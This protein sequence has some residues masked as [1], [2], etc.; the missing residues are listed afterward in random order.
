MTLL[1]LGKQVAR[2]VLKPN[3]HAMPLASGTSSSM[4]VSIVNSAELYNRY[5]GMSI[6]VATSPSTPISSV[7]GSKTR[8]RP[9]RSIVSVGPQP[10]SQILIDRQLKRYLVLRKLDR[11]K[12]RRRPAPIRPMPS[13][14]KS[15]ISDAP[16]AFEVYEV[17]DVRHRRA[18]AAAR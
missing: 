5:C 6:C 13:F 8:R 14:V 17:R 10:V 18:R 11:V 4:P 16:E 1:A 9:R 15:V 7:S 2:R 12:R 3:L